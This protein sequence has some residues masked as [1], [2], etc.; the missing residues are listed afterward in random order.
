MGLQ[1]LRPDRKDETYKNGNLGGVRQWIESVNHTLK[2]QL[3]LEEHGGRTTH[4][5]FA[6]VAPRRWCGAGRGWRYL[7]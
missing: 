6:R 4:G 3:G 2:G 1:L 5:V 7:A